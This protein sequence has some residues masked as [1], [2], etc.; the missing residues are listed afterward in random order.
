MA[1]RADA[2]RNRFRHTTVVRIVVVG[3]RVRSAG[4]GRE[5][6][7]GW[8]VAH[9]RVLWVPAS[10]AGVVQNFFIGATITLSEEVDV[11]ADDDRAAG[12]A[13]DGDGVAIDVGHIEIE[14][15]G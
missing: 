12:G 7:A 8:P 11:A 13:G 4:A 1:A 9:G 15:R 6:L 5:E 2:A 10:G 14:Q 3:E